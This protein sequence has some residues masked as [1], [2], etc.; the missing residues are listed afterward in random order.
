[1]PNWCFNSVEVEGPA[2]VLEAWVK[3][4][5][6]NA[7]SD[8]GLFG[9]F[10]I[11]AYNED[12]SNW[13]E[14]HNVAWG[15]KWDIEINKLDW[16][17]YVDGV[18]LRFDTAWS[19]PMGWLETMS[20]DWPSLLFRIAFEEGGMDF[21]GYAIVKDGEYWEAEGETV[22]FEF[23]CDNP[24]EQSRIEDAWHDAMSERRDQLMHEASDAYEKAMYVE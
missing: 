8:T 20:R 2:R 21:M 22:P 11:P 17:R 19:P 5:E 16:D 13:W 15:T 1:M 4:V 24:S 23:V 9:T 10:V 18:K 3:K 12:Q 14:A 7:G 6:R